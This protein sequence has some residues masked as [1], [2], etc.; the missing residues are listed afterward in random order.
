MVLAR[1][2]LG[3]ADTTPKVACPLHKKT[4]NLQNG[5]GLSDPRYKIQTF[6]VKVEQDEIWLLLPPVED[7]GFSRHI[8]RWS[9]CWS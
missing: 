7:L 4:F 9:S 1:G 5:E 6:D 2:L 8:C 3:E